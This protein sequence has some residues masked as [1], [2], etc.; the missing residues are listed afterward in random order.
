MR[1]T[2]R[3][4]LAA[5]LSAGALAATPVLA[6]EDEDDR[7][8]RGWMMEENG[9]G[10]G[11]MHGRGP[12]MM[13]GE[14][15]MMDGHGFGM[16]RGWG[17]G[18]RGERIE[19]RLAFLRAELGIAPDQEEAWERFADAMREN[20]RTMRGMRRRLMSGG[21]PE[22]LPARLDLRIT[23]MESRLAAMRRMREALGPLHD[24][25]GPEQRETAR[26]LMGMM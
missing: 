14:G 11:M 8:G 1:R 4:A 15:P 6:S 9:A 23:M 25:L 10:R 19:G 3:F 5:A 7:R 2:T 13:P 26:E 21:M 20:A 24:A 16:G 17:I 22:S 18:R 12:M